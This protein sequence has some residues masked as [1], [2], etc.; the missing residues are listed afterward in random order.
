M[1]ATIEVLSNYAKISNDANYG[2]KNQKITQIYS[3]T[4]ILASLDTFLRSTYFLSERDSNN[5]LVLRS[6]ISL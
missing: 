4:Q 2:E 5:L 1:G 6:N 3:I